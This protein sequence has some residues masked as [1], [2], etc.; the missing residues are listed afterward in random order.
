[1][2][3][4]NC[5]LLINVGHLLLCLYPSHAAKARTGSQAMSAQVRRVFSRQHAV[6]CLVPNPESMQT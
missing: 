4:C 6:A 2:F 3:L 1:M 5:N